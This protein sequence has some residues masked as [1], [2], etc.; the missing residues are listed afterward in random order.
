MKMRLSTS[1]STAIAEVQKRIR[2]SSSGDLLSWDSK[3]WQEHSG[4]RASPYRRLCHSPVS[5]GTNGKVA[6]LELGPTCRD[7]TCLMEI[8]PKI[9]SK[10]SGP[11]E[12][13]KSILA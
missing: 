12:R 13:C 6:K 8:T 9:D 3:V 1:T 2:R 4:V 10:I 11:P 7:T 5:K